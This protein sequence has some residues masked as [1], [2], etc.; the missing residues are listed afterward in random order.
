MYR[1]RKRRWQVGR[2]LR[3]ED[4][5]DCGEDRSYGGKGGK[6]DEREGF[7]GREKERSGGDR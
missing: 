3:K 4:E 5:G 6:L 1:G 2:G 7:M